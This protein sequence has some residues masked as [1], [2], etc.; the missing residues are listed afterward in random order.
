MKTINSTGVSS[1]IAIGT[2]VILVSYH[3]LKAIGK[4]TGT[5]DKSDPDIL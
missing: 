4:A 3:G 5:I 2:I 1:G